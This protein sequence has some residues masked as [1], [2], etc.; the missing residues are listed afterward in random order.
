MADLWD[1]GV[2]LKCGHES[3]GARSDVLRVV[4]RRRWWFVELVP[5]VWF[6]SLPG[7]GW[8]PAVYEAEGLDDA[9][10]WALHHGG[11]QGQPAVGVWPLVGEAYEVVLSGVV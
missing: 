7:D 6:G 5:S 2:L 8:R 10:G 1:G 11:V 3:V 9:V 4:Q